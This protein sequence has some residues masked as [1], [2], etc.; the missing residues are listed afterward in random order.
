MQTHTSFKKRKVVVQT[1]KPLISAIEKQRQ[2]ISV[3]KAKQTKL[4]VV[5]MLLIL[6]LEGQR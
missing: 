1:F 5:L 6:A 4:D 2:T 3:S